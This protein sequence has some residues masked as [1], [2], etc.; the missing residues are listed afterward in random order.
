MSRVIKENGKTYLVR[1]IKA[2]VFLSPCVVENEAFQKQPTPKAQFT[3]IEIMKWGDVWR[4]YRQ[5]QERKLYGGAMMRWVAGQ[6][7][8]TMREVKFFLNLRE[9]YFAKQG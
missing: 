3:E 7:G 9:D 1:E 8:C 4:Y 2:L 6:A 5:A